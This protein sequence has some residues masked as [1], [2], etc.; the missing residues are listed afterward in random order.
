MDFFKLENGKVL[1][2][3]NK[4]YGEIPNFL[5][6]EFGLVSEIFAEVTNYSDVYHSSSDKNQLINLIK[7]YLE[8]KFKKIISDKEISYEDLEEAYEE[9]LENFKKHSQEIEKVIR[10]KTESIFKETKTGGDKMFKNLKEAKLFTAHLDALANEI[11]NLEDVSEEMRT[12]LAY[13]L[14]KLSDLIEESTMDK[15]ANGM[16]HGAWKHDEDEPY[17]ATMGGTGALQHDMDEPYMEHFKDADHMEVL[18]RK[19]PAAVRVSS[20]EDT[21]D[22]LAK[23]V[24]KAMAKLK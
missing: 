16:G 12:H 21:S 9:E 2:N 22:K 13:R 3:N 5:E 7:N 20:E 11:Q 8:N 6:K 23:Y 18:K 1:D 4:N 24:K 10:E 14:D 17:M 19:E 15:Q